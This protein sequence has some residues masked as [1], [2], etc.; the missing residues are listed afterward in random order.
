[1]RTIYLLISVI[2]T[3]CVTKNNCEQKEKLISHLSSQLE[4]L[5]TNTANDTMVPC[6]FEAEKYAMITKNDWCCGFPAGS[7]WYMY[8]LTGDKKWEQIAIENTVK[9]DGVQYLKDTHDLGF[10]VFSSYG[11]AYRITKNEDYKKVII[12]ASPN[13]YRD[14]SAAAITASALYLLSLLTDEGKTE[15]TALSGKILASLGSPDYLAEIGSNGGFLIKHCVGN[16][17]GKSEVDVPQ[18]YTD[19]YYLEALKYK[20]NQ[21]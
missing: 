5:V 19:Y 21:K 11:N 8:E 18:T 6:T 15:Y 4:Y 9:L 17:P 13:T 10:M 1:M 20:F 2:L 3:G 16:L 12:Q 7:Y 14:A